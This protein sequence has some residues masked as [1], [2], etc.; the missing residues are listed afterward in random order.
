MGK[1]VLQCCRTLCSFLSL[2]MYVR[3]TQR[4]E[5]LEIKALHKYVL[6]LLQYVWLVLHYEKRRSS[7]RKRPLVY[8]QYNRE[9]NTFV[10]NYLLRITNTYNRLWLK[11]LRPCICTIWVLKQL[12][13]DFSWNQRS[14][15]WIFNVKSGI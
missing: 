14:I 15:K 9:N 3:V 5:L 4:F 12:N 6:L 11:F 8:K 7:Y 1:F 10:I 13:D 2:K